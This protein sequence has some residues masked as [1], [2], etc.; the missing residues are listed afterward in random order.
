MASRA[1]WF[2]RARRERSG[3]T[4]WLRVLSVFCASVLPRHDCIQLT[5]ETHLKRTVT[6][7]TRRVQCNVSGPTWRER[8]FGYSSVRRQSPGSSPHT[9]GDA[10]ASPAF[11]LLL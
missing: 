4:E 11:A 3:R 9:N 1:R 10:A 7:F 5:G 2:F 6:T 8:L